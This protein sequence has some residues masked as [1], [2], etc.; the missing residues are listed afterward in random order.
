MRDLSLETLHAEVLHIHVKNF[1]GPK[2]EPLL[3]CIREDLNKAREWPIPGM[4]PD[5]KH[6]LSFWWA[7]YPDLGDF[8]QE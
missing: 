8:I 1:G 3:K 2:I 4:E 6:P 7:R 5:V